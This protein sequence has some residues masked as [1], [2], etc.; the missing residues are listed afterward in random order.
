[1]NR[2]GKVNLS[3]NHANDMS[4]NAYLPVRLV[5]FA[6]RC[7]SNSSILYSSYYMISDGGMHFHLL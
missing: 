3:T 6:Y 2:S 4:L 1:M 7:K 5:V